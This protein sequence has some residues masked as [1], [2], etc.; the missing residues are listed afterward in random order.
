M[1][2]NPRINIVKLF[3]IIGAIMATSGVCL[4]LYNNFSTKLV[5]STSEKDIKETTSFF[6]LNKE[7]KY[8][9]FNIN[10]KKLTDFI[11]TSVT[12]FIN[13]KAVVK[14]NDNV[15]VI[16]ATGKMTV[17]FGKYKNISNASGLFK[18]EKKNGHYELINGHGKVLYNM[19]YVD[20]KTYTDGDTYSILEDN[21]KK[22]YTVL[23][24]EGKKLE[25]FAKEENEKEPTTNAA[26]NYISVFYKG[27]NRIF[28]INTGKKI[29]DFNDEEHYCVN[30]VINDRKAMV[31]NSCTKWY[32]KQSH[33]YYKII[34]QG[35][36]YDIEKECSTIITNEG[37]LLCKT[38]DSKEYLFDKNYKRSLEVSG[39][40]AYINENEYAVRKKNVFGEVDIYQDNKVIKNIACRSLTKT[41]Y[42]T[43]GFYI[44]GTY[45]SKDCNTESG[46]YEFY[47]T[48]GE[49]A[50]DKSFRY[51]DKFDT[52]SNAIVSEDRKNYYLINNKG[53]QVG[54]FYDD[55]KSHYDYYIVTKE[56]KKGMIN[57][58]G[59]ELLP[60]KYSN[61]LVRKN[62]NKTYAILTTQSQMKEIYNLDDNRRLL[63]TNKSLE[64]HS[65]YILASDNTK[66]EYYTIE[67]GKLFFEETI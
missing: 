60:C 2:I 65:N 56:N 38:K 58:D 44:V 41:G 34:D 33:Q 32:E 7:N 57:K 22:T 1:K 15:G 21:K 39:Y 31:L 40:K 46:I 4:T 29:A 52:N 61:I 16:D 49:K 47:K 9:L 48:N 17:K 42:A 59:K 11:Y 37:H 14:Q 53:N 26:D 28:N 13:E 51:A 64:W 12:D 5:T 36:L 27:K 66:K 25:T 54:N 10:G 3:L 18:A 67:K 43:E 24:Y 19:D 62:K 23:N 55:I 35:K 30:T 45:Y 50:F 6:L 8:A 20:L 63:T